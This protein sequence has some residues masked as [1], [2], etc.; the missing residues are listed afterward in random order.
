M[1]RLTLQGVVL[2]LR[3]QATCP[4]YEVLLLKK[5]MIERRRVPRLV[6]VTLPPSS[7]LSSSVPLCFLYQ[8]VSRLIQHTGRRTPTPWV[9]SLKFTM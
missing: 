4:S 8:I 1:H 6:S 7:P 3:L 2:K 5:L 9:Y